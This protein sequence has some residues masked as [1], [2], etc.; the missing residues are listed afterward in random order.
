MLSKKP[1]Q[2]ELVLLFC[3]AMFMSF[4][5]AIIAAMLL[6]N[7]GVTGFKQPDDF[8]FVL[9]GTL[10][11]QGVAWI[12]IFIFLRLHG[13]GWR[14]AFGLRNPNLEKSLLLALVVLLLA[15]P[16]V[17]LLQR[18]SI[19]LLTQLG[20]PPENQEAVQMFLDEKSVWMRIY[21][22]LF[23]VILAPVAEEFI[24][25]GMLFPF[26]KEMGWPKL[27]WFGVSFLF[28]LIHHDAAT[29]V[30]LFVLALAFTW[31]YAKTDCLLA[32]VFAHALFNAGNLALLILA[33]KFGDKFPI[34]P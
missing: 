28:A 9:L 22:G 25:R 15:S 31:L 1:W 12:L 3:A 30:P 19:T 16:I 32:S 29:F 24:F 10:S 17:L 21:F 11:V 4:G 26:F 20:F 8:G 7:A 33:E 34:Q 6:R 27:A 14:D 13:T 23:A 5:G 2:P 18:L